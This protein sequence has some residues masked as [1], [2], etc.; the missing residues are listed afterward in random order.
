MPVI[1]YQHLLRLTHAMIA[2]LGTPD[3]L[4]HMV[5]GSLV[6]ANLRGHDSHGVLR[7]PWYARFVDDGRLLPAARPSLA[8][9][10][11]ATARIDGAFGWGQ[12]AARLAA[13]TAVDLA[14]ECG[15]GLTIIERGNHIGRVGE[16]VGLIAEAGMVGMAWCNASPSVAPF[17]GRHRLM[18]TNPFAWAAPRGPGRAP[19]ILDFATSI[20]AEGKLRVARAAGQSLDPGL[21]LDAAGH[22]SQNADDFYAGGA[23]VPFGLH[24]G[25]GL[26]VMIELLARAVAGVEHGATEYRGYNGTM[27]LAIAMSG[28]VDTDRY[29]EAAERFCAA[30]ES[31]EPA[32]GVPRVLLPGQPEEA[33]RAQRLVDGIPL[34]ARTWDDI[35]ALA[36]DLRVHGV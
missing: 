27:L 32:D 7:L 15:I 19:L 31:S 33:I 34:A 24:K 8:E 35:R 1:H 16:Y 22:P 10:R 23:L 28:V 5:A 12:P 14:A 11:G 25:S 13:G 26:S 36:A 18:G 9:Q 30:V 21:I 3:D 4:A 6:E 20:V 17:G 29:L 2:A